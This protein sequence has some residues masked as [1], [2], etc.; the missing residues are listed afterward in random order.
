MKPHL[1]FIIAGLSAFVIAG[2]GGGGGLDEDVPE[3]ARPKSMDSIVLTMDSSVQ[4]EFVRNNGT[5]AA[6]RTGEI[7]TGTF[8]YTLGGVQR[9]T[10]PNQ[11]GDNSDARYPDSISTASYTYLAIN[12]TSGLLTLNGIGVNDLNDT[13]N[14]AAQ[15][16]SFTY[17]FNSDS[18]SNVIN[19]VEID[20]SFNLNGNIVDTGTVTVRIPGSTQ[21]G[22]D[23]VRV[24]TSVKLAND[25]PVPYNYN[26]DLENAESRIAPASLNNTLVQFTNGGGDPNF[27]FTIQFVP[28]STLNPPGQTPTEVGQGFLRV[29]GNPIQDAIDYTWQRINGTDGGTLVISRSNQTFDGSYNLNFAGRDNGTYTGS[30]DG[31]TPD[32]A[33]VTGTFFIPGL[34]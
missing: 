4:F 23:T 13:G 10:Y 9:R 2:C 14:F 15:N 34:N 27:D 22:Y 16:G 29:A 6:L 7:E 17:F 21:P 25:S 31:D 1:G 28:E 19:S 3:T 8:F 20:L 12:E 5:A 30:T 26:P 24:P 33:E 32:A 18:D 11:Q